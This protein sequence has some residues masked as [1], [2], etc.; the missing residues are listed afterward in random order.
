MTIKIT[1]VGPGAL[2]CLFAAKLAGGGHSVWLLDHSA[3]RAALL[4]V[5]G[6]SLETDGEIIHVPVRAVSAPEV[7]VSSD[8][9]F[10]CVKSYAIGVAL[11]RLGPLFADGE[12]LLIA[13]QNGISHH[14]VLRQSGFPYAVGIT[15]QGGTLVGVG[16]VVH[17]GNGKTIM[18]FLDEAT[19]KSIEKLQAIVA[20]LSAVHLPATGSE[21]VVGAV[22]D[23]LIVN[24]GIN[25]LT[26][27]HNC[28][29]GA[30]LD[31]PAVVRIQ[32]AAVAEAAAVAAAR[33]IVLS[34]DPLAMTMQVCRDTAHNISS[35]LQD[36]RHGR[37]TEVDAINGAIVQEGGALGISTPVNAELVSALKSIEYAY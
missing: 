14:E 23:K 9:V 36:V 26:A 7:I 28:R 32:A 31:D 13:L 35:M 8:V 12:A 19:E 25:A 18:G 5:K 3:Q 24:V 17:G 29:N 6:V 2:G 11:E 1:I 34:G 16:E 4:D 27:I 33:G 15:A 21:N 20:A 22:W 30:L 10:L 37:R